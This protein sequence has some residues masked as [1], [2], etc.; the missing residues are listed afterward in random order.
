MLR[1]SVRRS[2]NADIVGEGN[3]SRII[4]IAIVI[5]FSTISLDVANAQVGLQSQTVGLCNHFHVC[6]GW[7][8]KV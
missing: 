6:A 4:P 2:G 8:A 7:K 5:I 3:L 1:A